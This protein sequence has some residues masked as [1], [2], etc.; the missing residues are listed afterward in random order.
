MME[1]YV[2]I[3]ALTMSSSI[4]TIYSNSKRGR[5][6]KQS[7]FILQ[8]QMLKKATLLFDGVAFDFE[9]LNGTTIINTPILVK[10]IKGSGQ[11]VNIHITGLQL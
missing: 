5:L 3:N 10:S 11:G 2:T 1:E 4:E 6:S 7:Y 9:L 8:I